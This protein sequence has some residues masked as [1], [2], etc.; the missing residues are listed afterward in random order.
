[1]VEELTGR[2]N[3]DIQGRLHP[4]VGSDGV[5][6]PQKPSRHDGVAVGGRAIKE[7]CSSDGLIFSEGR[8]YPSSWR[9][10]LLYLQTPWWMSALHGRY[11]APRSQ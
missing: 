3:V 9:G 11:K 1:M 6:H 7:K 8:L 5:S 2:F 10:C 4:R